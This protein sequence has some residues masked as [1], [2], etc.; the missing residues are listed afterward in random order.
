MNEDMS[1]YADQHLDIETT[2]LALSIVTLDMD[3]IFGRKRA[4]CR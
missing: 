4:A 3:L 1:L 2:H